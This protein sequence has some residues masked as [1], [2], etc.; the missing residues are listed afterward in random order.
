MV[1]Y[2]TY[3]AVNMAT[4]GI[5]SIDETFMT[6][7]F[8]TLLVTVFSVTTAFAAVKSPGDFVVTAGTLNV[9]L[10]PSTSA[11]ARGKLHRGQVI[12]V[13]EVVDG[14]ARISRYYNGA[15]EGL[16]GTVAHWVFATH[17]SALPPAEGLADRKDP[18]VEVQPA[19]PPPGEE[20][21]VSAPI[22]DAIKSSDDL[23]KYQATFAWVSA[24]LVDSG[25]C[26]IS[27]FRDIGG[28]WRSADHKPR[29]VYYTYCGGGSN[30]DRIY[31]DT[32]TGETFR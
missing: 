19:M 1:Y 16:S 7:V 30:S 12:E 23:P 22:F 5:R 17:L 2:H 24:K 32:T 28:W 9:R 21:V 13:L 25:T 10:A 6:R 11:K 4:T 31:V 3:H 20:I 27:D 8:L 18:P 29:P 14:W 26:E 15:S